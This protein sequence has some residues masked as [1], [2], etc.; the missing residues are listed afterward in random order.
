VSNLEP[1]SNSPERALNA[2]IAEYYRQVEGGIRVDRQAFVR[3][4]PGLESELSDF[5]SNIGFFEVGHDGEESHRRHSSP[6][7]ASAL[8]GNETRSSSRFGRGGSVAQEVVM[9]R[10][11]RIL[12]LIGQG[13]MGSVYR[14]MHVRLQKQVALKTLKMERVNSPE[15]IQRFTREMRLLAKLDHVNIVKALDAG[16]HQGMHYFVM[17]LVAGIDLSQL[18][19]RLGPLP[20]PEVSKIICLAAEAL[21]YAHDQKILHRDVKPSNLMITAKGSVK[22]LDLGLAHIFEMQLED[23]ISR[24]DQAV[25]TLAYMAPEQ[26]ANS[27]QCS[28]QSDVFSLG[29]SLHELLSG[30]RPCYQGGSLPLVSD[31][32][33]IRPDLD[34]QLCQL[35]NEMISSSPGDRPQS[36]KEVAERLSIFEKNADLKGLVAKYYCWNSPG[37]IIP[38]PPPVCDDT[39]I[40]SEGKTLA[41]DVSLDPNTS[42][43]KIIRSGI[44]PSRRRTI[45]SLLAGA[46][47]VAGIPV[48]F[49]PN[50]DPPPPPPP[51][52]LDSVLEIISDADDEVIKKI[53][54]NGNLSVRPLTQDDQSVEPIGVIE[55]KNVLPPGRYALLIPGPVDFES[56]PFE[57]ISSGNIKILP[58]PTLKNNFQNPVIPGAGSLAKYKGEVKLLNWKT[59]T[60]YEL[61]LEVLSVNEQDTRQ[62]KWLKVEVRSTLESGPYQEVAYLKINSDEW[63]NRRNLSIEAGYVEASGASIKQWVDDRLP[64]VGGETLVVK[65]D[66]D[67]DLVKELLSSSLP[68]GR[69]SVHD[70]LVL[71][72]G[73]NR[74]NAADKIITLLR[75][76]LSQG[77]RIAWFETFQLSKGRSE[78]YVVSS[79]SREDK[80]SIGVWWKIVRTRENPFEIADMRVETPILTAT[81]ADDEYSINVATDPD[82]LSQTLA[83][84][85]ARVIDPAKVPKPHPFD[86]AKIPNFPSSV[87]VSGQI[88]VG[89]LSEEID[90]T[91]SMLGTEDI[92]EKTL[93]WLELDVTTRREGIEHKETA[94]MLVD[95]SEYPGEP[96]KIEQGWFAFDNGTTV[97]PLSKDNDLE[98]IINARLRLF[99]EPHF[100]HT[101][102]VDL[103]SMLFN[104]DFTPNS[105]LARLRRDID[106]KIQGRVGKPADWPYKTLGTSLPCMLHVPDGSTQVQY[107]F[108]RCNQIPF[109]FA[110]VELNV[111]SANISIHLRLKNDQPLGEPFKTSPLG[112]TEDLTIRESA[113]SERLKA[114]DQTNWHVWSWKDSGKTYKAWA[115]FGGT[116]KES[117]GKDDVFLWDDSGKERRIPYVHFVEEDQLLI[118]QGRVWETDDLGALGPL[119][120]M[121]FNADSL[122][123]GHCNQ[124]QKIPFPLPKY[125]SIDS[126][127]HDDRK[128]FEKHRKSK[129]SAMPD[130][131]DDFA[132]YIYIP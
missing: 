33:S 23:Q 22:L 39:E 56:M 27:Q 78:C 62:T 12:E 117:G 48:F 8:P 108:Y 110:E 46:A 129:R 49:L 113:T 92:E 1:N 24:T 7:V 51:P 14:A 15:A 119:V 124:G 89:G 97:L 60:D 41:S 3:Q 72:F 101:G 59:P 123:L 115:E 13:G 91:A 21:Q 30:K 34:D 90:F 95:A 32:R 93:H 19:A 109:G 105:K 66:P 98:S 25:G 20:I 16:E 68:E 11:Y 50:D 96:L 111:D 106:F 99:A 100:Q 42:G 71:Y 52:P 121:G 122:K 57:I 10:D 81:C 107:K 35:L 45:A 80:P 114:R 70:I 61:T 53:I 85:E 125:I 67:N 120:I 31:V 37:T 65:F 132:P 44:G 75:A 127:N 69:V 58:T 86:L 103:M 94:R 28:H 63:E 130:G 102:V 76:Q 79:H 83:N 4:Y 6:K 64:D 104:T 29:I 9:L 26:L 131:L 87:A 36:M 38:T 116:V 128:W 18:V 17:E 5:L 74:I 54:A 47:I 77:K 82:K 88:T 73:D 118:D 84:L 2:A 43:K 126:L 40:Y 55:G 112:L